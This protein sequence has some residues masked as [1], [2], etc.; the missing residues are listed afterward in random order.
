MAT[1]AEQSRDLEGK[2]RN[3]WERSKAWL[4]LEG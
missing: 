2:G 4:L 1:A 3:A